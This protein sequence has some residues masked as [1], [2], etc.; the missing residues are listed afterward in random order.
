MRELWRTLRWS[1]WLGWQIE[2]NWTEPWLFATYI[3]I[4]P[5]SSS[6]LLVCMYYAARYATDGA[7]P[8][9]FLP[10]IYISNACYG[11]VGNVMF[12]MSYTVISDREHYRMLKYIFISPAH[13][14]MFFVGRGLSRA[15]QASLGALLNLL[16]GWLVF[17]EIRQA[18]AVQPVA[19]GWLLLYLAMGVIFLIAL[20]L[21]MC[22]VL[23]NMGRQ[24][25]FLSEGIAGVLFLLSGTVFPL[26]VLPEPLRSLGLL[27]P[28][29][30]WLE[31]MRRALLGF[32]PSGTLLASSPLAD[33]SLAQLGLV[34][35]LSSLVLLLGARSIYRW[36]V[37]RAWR[38]GRLEENTGA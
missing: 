12:G 38:R 2:S 19:W 32:P 18:I 29:T 9:D 17:P 10:Y 8:T 4:K 11:I 36:G 28:T 14:P 23:L 27:L 37:H 21:T 1:T 13:F 35:A 24:G 34:V 6:L 16:V 3:L 15:A 22:G 33:S 31:A 26:S 30:Y 25:M 20:G 7:V 5:V